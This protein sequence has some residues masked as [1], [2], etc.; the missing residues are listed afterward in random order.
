MI[1]SEDVRN[2]VNF[3]FLFDIKKKKFLGEENGLNIIY[4]RERREKIVWYF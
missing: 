3:F 1:I 4:K 2:L